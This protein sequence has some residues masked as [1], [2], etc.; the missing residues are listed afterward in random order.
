M[1]TTN[2]KEAPMVRIPTHGPPV[3]PGEMLNEEFLKPLGMTQTAL[4]AAIGLSFQNVNAIV[5]GRR[6]VTPDVALR[7]ERLF[8]ASAQFWLNLQLAWDLYH[9]IHGPNAA[10]R[11]GIRRHP[12]VAKP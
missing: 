8:G 11:R 12:A 6:G 1:R 5:N 4:A 3:H 9:E 7:L 2:D 10:R